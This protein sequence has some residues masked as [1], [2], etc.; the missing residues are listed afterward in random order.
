[1]DLER[2]IS[3]IPGA[4][5]PYL[6]AGLIL[7]SLFCIL[8][9]LALAQKPRE[10]ALIR[11]TDAAEGKENADAAMPKEPNPMRAEENLDI[12]NFY[13][14]KKN[15]PAAIQRYLEAL[16]YQPNFIRAYEA[17][18]RAYEKNDELDKAM[19]TY[20]NFLKKYPDSPKSSDFL[21][22]LSKLKKRADG[23]GDSQE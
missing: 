13:F 8:P 19:D 12:G 2:Q 23:T 5:R 21:G 7:L 22:K 16:A 9:G 3:L 17:L 15:Y 1:M 4:L 18:A 14:K 20:R 6:L 10:P 11:D